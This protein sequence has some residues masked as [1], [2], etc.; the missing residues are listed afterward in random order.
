MCETEYIVDV[1]YAHIRTGQEITFSLCRP[2][3]RSVCVHVDRKLEFDQRNAD[4]K[5]RIFS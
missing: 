1:D 5:G 4:G 2:C 3:H